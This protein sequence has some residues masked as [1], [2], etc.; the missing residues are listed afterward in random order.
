MS[1]STLR[2]IR[3]LHADSRS[4]VKELERRKSEW[5]DLARYWAREHLLKVIALSR[6][7]QPRMDGPLALACRRAWSQLR[8]DEMFPPKIREELAS[9]TMREI[10]EKESPTG[11]IKVTMCT[12]LRQIPDWLLYFCDAHS[13]MALLGIEWP[14][15]PK[16]LCKL[17]MQNSDMHA[18][19]FLP[20]GV[21]EPWDQ[22]MVEAF[23]F[24]DQMSPEELMFYR[25]I[26][27]KPEEK[28]TRHE[29]RFIRAMHDHKSRAR[30][31]Q[32]IRQAVKQPG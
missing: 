13:S 27:M 23:R 9:Y 24:M 15:Y 26:R 21:L 18:W 7:G 1:R 17:F 3:R 29:H 31:L 14:P 20:Q 11:G 25:A 8:V 10:L 22:M 30:A 6:Y 5:E 12:A 4:T 2:R 16:D 19:P 32:K 28:W